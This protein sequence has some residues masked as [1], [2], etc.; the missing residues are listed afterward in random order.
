MFRVQNSLSHRLLLAV[1]FFGLL[2]PNLASAQYEG[3]DVYDPFADYSEFEDNS[4]EEAD[5]HFFRNG[6][7]FNIAFLMG[8]EQFTGDLGTYVDPSITPGF[9]FAYFFN[10]RFALQISYNYAQHRLLVNGDTNSAGEVFEQISG[11]VSHSA[12]GFNLKYYFNTQNVT[13]GF[14]ALNPYL[15]GGFSQIYRTFALEDLPALVKDEATGFDFGGGIEIPISDNRMYIGLQVVYHFVQFPAEN[16]S[17]KDVGGVD[18]EVFLSGDQ[19]DSHIIFGLN[20]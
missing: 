5:I 4:Q 18:T 3:D 8:W 2:S 7:F 12:I 15:L 1:L 9:Y 17:L 13:R 10:L 11:N 20:F 14:A 6:R 19:I 16:S